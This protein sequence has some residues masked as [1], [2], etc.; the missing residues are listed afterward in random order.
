MAFRTD[1]LRRLG[2]FPTSLGVR[3]PAQ[4][5]EDLAA[6]YEVVAGGGRLAYVPSAVVWHP[7]PRDR[8][9]FVDK[10][11]AYGVGLTAHLTRA[12]VRRPGVIAEIARRFPAAISYFLAPSSSRNQRRGRSFPAGAVRRAELEGMALGPFAYAR[13]VARRRRRSHARRPSGLSR[14]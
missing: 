14:T 9:A 8:A 7:H 1:L 11:R 5:G 2:G 4:G 6:L 10:L 12:I 3:T 13:S